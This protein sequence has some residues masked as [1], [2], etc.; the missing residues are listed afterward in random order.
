MYLEN[1]SSYHD[2][3]KQYSDKKTNEEVHQI[4]RK[5]GKSEDPILRCGW[6][7]ERMVLGW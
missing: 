5:P 3:A 2:A 7:F 1:N 6:K 4:Y